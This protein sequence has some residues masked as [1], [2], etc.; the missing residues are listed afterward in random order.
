MINNGFKTPLPWDFLGSP[1]V[2]TW[3]FHRRGALVGE[4]KSPRPH[5]TA[6]WTNK[7]CFTTEIY[8]SFMAYSGL[9]I[10]LI[11]VPLFQH[12][13]W[14]NSPYWGHNVLTAERK[15]SSTVSL[16]LIP[17][18]IVFIPTEHLIKLSLKHDIG[19]SWH[20]ARDQVKKKQA[21]ITVSTFS[22]MRRK[23]LISVTE[24]F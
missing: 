23:V 3:C 8:F 7:H 18:C 4:L 12:P 5:G 14:R 9:A 13:G 22:Q 11:H 2:K 19:L 1:G 15:K 24:T 16:W 21:Q 17:H 10:A 6:K 20:I